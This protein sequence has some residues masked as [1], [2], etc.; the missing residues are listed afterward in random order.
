MAV[1]LSPV[2]HVNF[3]SRL[4]P[5]CLR[6]LYVLACKMH[7]LIDFTHAGHLAIE[8]EEQAKEWSDH[9]M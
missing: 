6:V 3:F 7:G 1:Q 9:P 4:L 2:R 8:A 5:R